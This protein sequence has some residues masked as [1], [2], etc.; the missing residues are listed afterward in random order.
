MW[1]S[2]QARKD[3]IRNGDLYVVGP[4]PAHAA[5][6]SNCTFALWIKLSFQDVAVL[7]CHNWS[8]IA[9]GTK[10]CAHQAA[11]HKQSTV[12]THTGNLGCVPAGMSEHVT[13][14]TKPK[15][16]IRDVLVVQKTS[17]ERLGVLDEYDRHLPAKS[18][19]LAGQC[20]AEHLSAADI[21]VP[22]NEGQSLLILAIS[23]D[24][25]LW[26]AAHDLAAVC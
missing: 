8:A 15:R 7:D 3:K 23:P 21:S 11:T 18:T 4:S 1:L 26:P 22:K 12:W 14:I 24:P 9:T 20:D 17:S 13:S 25:R 10:G 6:P 16:P 2:P 19:H 5:N